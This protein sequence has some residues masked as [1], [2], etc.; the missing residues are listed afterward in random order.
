MTAFRSELR[1]LFTLAWPATVTQVGLML[2]G[3]V[4]TMVV[5]RTGATELAAAALAHMWMWSTLS[6]GIGAVMGTDPMISQAHGRGDGQAAALALQRGVVVAL[7]ASVPLCVAMALTGHTLRLLGQPP[8]VVVLAERYNLLRI[9]MIPCFLLFSA[10]RLFLQ[11]RGRMGP[12]TT[13]IWVA[14]VLNAL[15]AWGLVFGELGMPKL[16]FDGAALAGTATAAFE[17]VGLIATISWLGLARGAERAWDRSS[18]SPAGIA[19]VLRIGAPVAVQMWLEAFAFTFASFMV[20][21][22]SVDAIGAHQ[23]ALNLASLTFMV[24]LGVSMGASARVGN[25]IGAGDVA[26]M[27]GAVRVALIAGIG[28][29]SFSALGF[30]VLRGEL[31]RLYTAD[32]AVIAL[33]AQ[34]LPLAAAFQLSDGAQVVAGGVLRGMGRPN[35]AALANLLGYYALGLPL[36]YALAF[37]LGLGLRGIWLGLT[38]GLFSVSI[39]LLLWVRRTARRPLAELTVLP[40]PA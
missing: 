5:A 8:E 16:G 32:V 20:G 7:L 36:G 29:M 6:L 22:I 23:I 25:L 26:A 27:R 31:P 21:W 40:S 34:I 19:S 17:L 12:A 11:A 24:P 9:P 2:T 4:D 3:V 13:L 37:W 15:L 35:A 1:A 38:I 18:F 14:N 28:V 30:T 39:S 10:L 33:T